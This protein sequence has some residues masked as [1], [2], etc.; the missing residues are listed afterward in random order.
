MS[1]L[2]LFARV[3]VAEPLLALDLQ[4]FQTSLVLQ[5]KVWFAFFA[6]VG[7]CLHVAG[8]NTSLT[9]GDLFIA[10]LL[11]VHDIRI[12]V[13]PTGLVSLGVDFGTVQRRVKDPG[14]ATVVLGIQ[15]K[16]F[17]ASLAES[18]DLVVGRTILDSRNEYALV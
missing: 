4:P 11:V 18:T 1:V 3:S 10:S 2:A 16:R 15:P 7:S 14:H 8:G 12:V 17:F 6:N 5:E 9:S 13:A